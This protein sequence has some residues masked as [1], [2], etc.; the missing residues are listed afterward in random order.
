MKM[1]RKIVLGISAFFL[2]L[3]SATCVFAGNVFPVATVNSSASCPS[4]PSY[5]DPNFCS[6]FTPVAICQCEEKASPGWCSTPL[7]IYTNMMMMFHT[8]PASCDWAIAHG[9]IPAS[10]REACIDRWTCFKNGGSPD[11][12]ACQG[13]GNPCV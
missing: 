3:F 12:H 1:K 4:T 9:V 6:E 7:Q 10:D 13:N 8:I 11:G 5:Y 2:T